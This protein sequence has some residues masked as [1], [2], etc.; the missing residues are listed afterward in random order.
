MSQLIRK[1]EPKLLAT[2]STEKS[3]LLFLAELRT[4]V[5][6]T[7]NFFVPDNC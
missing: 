3:W 6:E 1:N 4:I 7:D 2:I 5:S